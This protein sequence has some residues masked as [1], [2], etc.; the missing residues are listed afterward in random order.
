M[1]RLFKKLLNLVLGIIL[2][3]LVV[4]VSKSFYNQLTGI[5]IGDLDN[6]RY[7]LWGIAAYLLVH[8]FF[9]K[10]NF[11]YNLGHEVV[12]VIS[13]WLSLGKARKIK[14]SGQGG[15]V[16]TTKSNF[17]INLSPYFV[18]IY[19]ILI[20]IAYFTI[21]RYQN[22]SAYVPYFIFG[23]GF[24]LA[25]HII[26]TVDVLKIKQ[27][28]LVKTGYLF[29]LVSIY[30]LNVILLGLVINLIFTGFS[31]IGM[32]SEF[33]IQSKELYSII[34]RQLFFVRVGV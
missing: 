23:I 7:F 27:P 24:T 5:G 11:F 4:P 33:W 10:P 22:I 28:D 26:M 19:P 12:H 18:P 8:L 3:P 29:S 32:L 31:F 17:F 16:Q 6:P 9:F 2:L 21:S 14:V 25:M 34:Y 15:S 13:T 20:S 1:V 30:V